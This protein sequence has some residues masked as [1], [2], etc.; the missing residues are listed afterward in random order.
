M[1]LKCLFSHDWK[2]YKR[3]ISMNPNFSMALYQA[4]KCNRCHRI[5]NYSNGEWV[6]VKPP[7]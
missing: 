4:R 5:D 3:R 6:T 1:N 7:Q 2:Y